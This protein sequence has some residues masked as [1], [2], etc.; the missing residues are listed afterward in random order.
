ML[1]PSEEK[2]YTVQREYKESGTEGTYKVLHVWPDYARYLVRGPVAIPRF[3]L[4]TEKKA[5]NSASDLPAVFKCF[6]NLRLPS[7]HAA[8]SLRKKSNEQG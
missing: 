3:V 2:A 5:N 6:P 4:R 7:S 1:L 8:M